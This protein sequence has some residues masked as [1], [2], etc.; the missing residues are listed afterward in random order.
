MNGSAHRRRRAV[1]G[2]RFHKWEPIRTL[3]AH[4]GGVAA[5]GGIILV[6]SGAVFSADHTGS[7]WS[8]N[9]KLHR[10]N[11]LPAVMGG[12]DREWWVDG[13]RHRDGDLPAEECPSGMKYW[14]VDGKLHRGGGLPAVEWPGGVKYWWVD[15]HSVTLQRRRMRDTMDELKKR[16]VVHVI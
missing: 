7:R 15:G 3:G 4:L 9:G 16:V 8:V 5:G 1:S 12:G 13:K 10:D 6:M 14:R 11:G 2:P